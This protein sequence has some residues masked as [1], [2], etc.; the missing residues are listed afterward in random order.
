LFYDCR[1]FNSDAKISKLFI[2]ANISK[3]FFK[4]N[5]KTFTNAF[6]DTKIA[7][8]QMRDEGAATA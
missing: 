3:D 6:F 2:F 8:R 4:I 1:S 5:K 7:S